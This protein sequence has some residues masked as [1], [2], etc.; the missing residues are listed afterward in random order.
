MKIKTKF[1][2]ILLII[3]IL[4]IVIGIFSVVSIR[5]SLE[6]NMI[7]RTKGEIAPFVNL[8][9]NQHVPEEIFLESDLKKTQNIFD[10]FFEEIDT[11]EIIR[12]KVWDSKG[13]IIASDNP[14]I[15]GQTFSDD[16]EFQKAIKGEV[17]AEIN[18]LEK[19]ENIQEIGYGQLMEVYV[20]I[21]YSDGEVVGIV[22]TYTR[23]D[24]LNTQIENAQKDLM[25][26]IL[27]V[28][29]FSFSIIIILL[30]IFY[31]NISHPI[32]KLINFTTIIGM[33]NL[34]EKIDV[35]SK[36]EISELALSIN[37]MVKD[38]K[39]STISKKELEKQVKDKTKELQLKVDE[40]EKFNK[41]TVGR[42]L[43]MIE[44]K[45]R[46][47]ELESQLEKKK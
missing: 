38:L 36:D 40:L 5:E 46:I 20:P 19:A 18:P 12:I 45:K 28:L 42:E 29:I 43:K 41:L 47:K 17:I 8:Q 14:E 31:R 7:N 39:E 34:N 25:V 27:L 35:K 24:N 11:D 26:K 16:D 32:N 15:V 9:T 23:L 33:G 2:I 21:I 44:L 3:L 1:I 4:I 6:E 10:I 22:E 30:F 37:K 13:K